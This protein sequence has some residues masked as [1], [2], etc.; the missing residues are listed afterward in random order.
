MVSATGV[1][2]LIAPDVPVTITVTVLPVDELELEPQPAVSSRP[3]ASTHTIPDQSISFHRLTMDWRFRLRK[4]NTIP[5]GARPEKG[6]QPI[7]PAVTYPPGGAIADVA[8][9]NV[10]LAMLDPGVIVV[11]EKEQVTPAGAV[12][13]SEIAPLNPPLPLALTDISVDCPWARLRLCDETIN[14]KS[15]VVTALAG[16]IVA[17]K[18]LLRVGPPAVK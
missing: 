8:S 13:L 17:N 7:I 15:P 18:P 5:S 9:I 14:V 12:Q 6:N 3:S 16:I 4:A 10:E 11:G 1:V 2:W